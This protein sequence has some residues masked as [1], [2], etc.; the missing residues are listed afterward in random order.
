M[1]KAICV[2]KRNHHLNNIL[3]KLE[4]LGFVTVQEKKGWL[5]NKIELNITE[6]GNNEINERVHE[7]QDKWANMKNAYESGDK[8]KLQQVMKDEKS[9]L[10]TTTFI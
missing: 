5:G 4:S 3:E 6:K 7:L 10:P 8:Q 1:P 2:Q 9:F